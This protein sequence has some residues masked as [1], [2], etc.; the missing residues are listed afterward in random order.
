MN[1]QPRIK[2]DMNMLDSMVAM[3]DG[4]PGAATVCAQLT[5]REEGVG[6]VDICHLDDME[7]YGENI[8]LCYKDICGEDIEE[9][10][11]RVRD[12]SIK[13]DLVA[14]RKKYGMED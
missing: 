3:S 1:Q 9:L 6:F 13:K 12:R 11:K 7:I 10:S 4:N 14:L 8:W 5:Q 2:L